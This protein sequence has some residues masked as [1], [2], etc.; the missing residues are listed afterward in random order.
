MGLDIALGI[1]VVLGAIRGW[2]KG[3]VL[4]AIRLGGLVGCV[5]AAGPI[6]DYARPYVVP[7]LGT[8]PATMLDRMLW[9]SSA[10]VSYVTMVGLASLAVKLYRRRPYGEPEPNHADQF[11]G[12]L[13]SAGKAAVVAAFLVGALDKYALSWVKQVPWA[14]EMTRSSTVL[15]WHERYHPSEKIWD[16]APVQH[17][18]GHVQKM[19]VADPVGS[20][21][22]PL[23]TPEG[24]PVQTASRPPRL[25]LPSRDPLDPSSP[26]FAEKFD[27]EL[28]KLDRP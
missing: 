14:T 21:T 1:M 15:T 18:V 28:R 5:Y 3:F 17:F 12:M 8:I 25:D 24:R 6:R 16:A 10:V 2:F 26:D 20:T 4:Q 11:A 27:E 22:D 7:Y 19:G 9:W 23:S 13:L